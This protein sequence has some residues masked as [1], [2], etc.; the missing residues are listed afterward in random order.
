MLRISW[1]KNLKIEE[2][3]PRTEEDRRFL[4][5]LKRS[6][7]QL[8]EHILRHDSLTK[9]VIEG[10][11]SGYAGHE[12]RIIPGIKKDGKQQGGVSQLPSL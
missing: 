5:Q 3:F 1:V 4:K 6:R 10:K 11:D 9:K 8:I 12:L 2:V 7:A